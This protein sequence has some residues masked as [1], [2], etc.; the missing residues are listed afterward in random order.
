M[1]WQRPHEQKKDKLRCKGSAPLDLRKSAADPRKVVQ[2]MAALPSLSPFKMWK[3]PRPST[4]GDRSIPAAQW[5]TSSDRGKP[6]RQ[7]RYPKA[8]GENCS[9]IK[10]GN[11]LCA[12]LHR[13]LKKFTSTLLASFGLKG[14]AEQS[15]PKT[16]QEK[17]CNHPPNSNIATS[18]LNCGCSWCW[19]CLPKKLQENVAKIRWPIS[20]PASVTA[21][22]VTGAI[23]GGAMVPTTWEDEAVALWQRHWQYT[24]MSNGKC[25]HLHSRY[26]I[27]YTSCVTTCYRTG[28][29]DSL[30][31]CRVRSSC[32]Q[33]HINVSQHTAS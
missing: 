24:H 6:V 11:L 29:H 32:I 28:M 27:A 13:L 9:A 21:G 17:L 10:T 22:T 23:W 25:A 4:S 15:L 19:G 33:R 8:A 16:V 3:P 2:C 30:Y 26:V 14:L 31:T 7:Q 1:P 20:P 18:V 12:G 5:K